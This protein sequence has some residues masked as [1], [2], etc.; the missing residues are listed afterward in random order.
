[1]K[2]NSKIIPTKTKR[3]SPQQSIQLNIYSGYTYQQ[4]LQ[5]EILCMKLLYNTYLK[6]GCTCGRNRPHFPIM[7]SY[8]TKHGGYIKMTHQGIDLRH[9]KKKKYSMIESSS[10]L[11]IL[12]GLLDDNSIKQQ[13]DCILNLL[14]KA[15][16]VHLDLNDNGKN[17][18]INE[19]GHLSII[20]FDIMYMKSIDSY[21]TLTPLMHKR[22]SR[23][24]RVNFKDKLLNIVNNVF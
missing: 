13:V 18:C 15:N 22:I 7:I 17:I 4:G 2:D 14:Q 16:I 3:I 6:Y 23:F 19:D 9:L 1:M 24:K 20:D 12:N 21:K 10:K 5:R 11:K 8:S